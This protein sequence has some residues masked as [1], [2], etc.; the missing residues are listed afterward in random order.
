MLTYADVLPETK[1]DANELALSDAIKQVLC[2][3]VC[4]CVFVCVCVCVCVCVLIEPQ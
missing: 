4:V 1:K 3:C 2:V